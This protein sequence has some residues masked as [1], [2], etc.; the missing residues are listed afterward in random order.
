MVCKS[1]RTLKTSTEVPRQVFNGSLNESSTKVLES[2]TGGPPRQIR[3][4][5][6]RIGYR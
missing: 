2:P 1:Y 3:L 6:V 4:G 5:I